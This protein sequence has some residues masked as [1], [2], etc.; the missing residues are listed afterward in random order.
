VYKYLYISFHT[1]TWLTI[2]PEVVDD[3]S[4]R[5]DDHPMQT[6]EVID[7]SHRDMARFRSEQD[8]G[9]RQVI[10]A[11]R[12]YISIIK[13]KGKEDDVERSCKFSLV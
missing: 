8:P 11:L 12:N 6:V 10:A 4:S 2:I 7:A 3:W 13:E 5:F 1:E 9:F